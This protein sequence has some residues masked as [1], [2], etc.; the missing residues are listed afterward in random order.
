MSPNFDPYN[1]AIVDQTK[2]HLLNDQ[3]SRGRQLLKWVRVID[4]AANYEMIIN[5]SLPPYLYTRDRI[6]RRRRTETFC[7][8]HTA[9]ADASIPILWVTVTQKSRYIFDSYQFWGPLTKP[10]YPQ[11]RSIMAIQHSLL[12]RQGE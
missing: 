7:I 11:K 5:S 1:T 4:H 2:D 6:C 9:Y 10:R 8:T 12:T 3:L